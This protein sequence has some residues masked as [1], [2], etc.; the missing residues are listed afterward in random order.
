MRG[1]VECGA[2]AFTEHGE[3]EYHQ[4]DHA[5]RSQG[6]PGCGF[7]V[8]KSDLDHGAPSGG[9]RLGAEA[10]EADARF[11]DDGEADAQ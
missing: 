10:D 11:G 4:E 9:W 5:S 8:L 2:E 7:Q 1:G 6:E 3:G